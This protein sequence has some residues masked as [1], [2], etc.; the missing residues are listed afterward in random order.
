[1]LPPA[2]PP[3]C[4]AGGPGE[5]APGRDW[6]SDQ[7]PPWLAGLSEEELAGLVG[8]TDEE[9]TV[10][11]ERLAEELARLWAEPDAARWDGCEDAGLGDDLLGEPI[12][13]FGGGFAGGGVLDRL[14]PGPAL[15]GFSQ[16]VLDEGL[17]ALSD[18]ELVGVLRAS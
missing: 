7:E 15:A 4:G 10:L 18:D 5:S 8:P 17:G 14:G 13:L 12:A 16:G 6:D 11:D 1:M 2:D 9:L 3:P